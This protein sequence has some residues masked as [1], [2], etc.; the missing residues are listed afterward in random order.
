MLGPGLLNKL[1]AALGKG[2]LLASDMPACCHCCSE[3]MGSDS[4]DPSPLGFD[5]ERL[6]SLMC[7][8]MELACSSLRAPCII[9]AAAQDAAR[10]ARQPPANIAAALL[11][12]FACTPYL[13]AC[14]LL[15]QPSAPD[16]AAPVCPQ[17]SHA[18]CRQHPAGAAGFLVILRSALA[19]TYRVTLMLA[20]VRMAPCKSVKSC[21]NRHLAQHPALCMATML[22][23]A[24]N[25]GNSQLFQRV[26]FLLTRTWC[27]SCLEGSCGWDGRAKRQ[28]RIYRAM[29]QPLLLRQQHHSRP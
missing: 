5:P 20:A 29:W 1:F 26:A 9:V 25:P 2:R 14:P 11:P 15:T 12:C 7:R 18:P 19:A 21:R 6:C 17:Q 13:R 28:G 23:A 3:G 27:C 8:T 16:Q 22:A 24:P 10:A 4:T